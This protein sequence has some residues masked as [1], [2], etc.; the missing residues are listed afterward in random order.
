MMNIFMLMNHHIFVKRLVGRCTTVDV[1]GGAGDAGAIRRDKE[2]G[3][4]RHL[5]TVLIFPVSAWLE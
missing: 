5:S 4:G 1:D 2:H 3:D